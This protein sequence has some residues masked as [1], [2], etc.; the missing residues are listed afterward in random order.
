MDPVKFSFTIL[1]SKNL[2]P[3]RGEKLFIRY[4]SRI[5][6]RRQKKDKCK[7]DEPLD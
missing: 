5:K 7:T 3:G 4:I 1:Y 2:I 6:P